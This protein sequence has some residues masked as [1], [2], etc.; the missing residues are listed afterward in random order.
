MGLLFD[1]IRLFVPSMSHPDPFAHS[2]EVLPAV[3]TPDVVDILLIV[4][5]IALVAL[6]FLWVA[7]RIPPI[8]GWELRQGALL[9]R[10]QAFGKG[11]VLV[12]GKPD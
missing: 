8:A 5:W 9:R 2:L 12:L 11:H 10:E 6:T 4:G 7:S 3:F 1:R